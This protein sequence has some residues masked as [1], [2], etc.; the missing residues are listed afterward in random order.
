MYELKSVGRPVIRRQAAGRLLVR[1][2]SRRYSSA[3]LAALVLVALCGPGA[4]AA[5][6][7]DLDP[8]FGSGGKITTGLGPSASVGATEVVIQ[9]D[10]KIVAAGGS[11]GFTLARYNADGNLDAS[12]G[13]SGRVSAGFGSCWPFGCGLA[14]QADGKIVVAGQSNGD[15][16]LARFNPNGSFDTTFDGDGK[17]TTDFGSYDDKAA[18]VAVQPDGKIVA[19]GV[20]NNG[21][22]YGAGHRAEFALARYNPNGSLDASFDGDGKVTTHFDPTY[23]ADAAYD[24]AVRADGT[25][26]VAGVAE[27]GLVRNNQVTGPDFAVAAYTPDGELD[28][29]FGAVDPNNPA[30]R[31]GVTRVDIAARSADYAFSLGLDSHGNIVVGG[32]FYRRSTYG[33]IYQVPDIH[34]VALTRFTPDGLLDPTFGVGGRVFSEFQGYGSPYLPSFDL[35]VQP[36]DKIVIAG[37]SYEFG[38]PGDDFAVARYTPL[39]LLDGAF[40]ANG[41]V[42]T[43]FGSDYEEPYGV[44]VQSD[45]KIV[46]AGGA[47]YYNGS[48]RFD[49][50]LARYLG[51]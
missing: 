9:S 3:L 37:R 43:D 40:G 36:D 47:G 6:P 17:L 19:V 41:I 30:A 22:A 12:F 49:F 39:G 28:T 35:A 34:G 50:A 51:D 42:T 29:S 16:A 25:I 24:V 44:A 7:G 2:R 46:A 48:F 1:G 20:F 15:F 32:Y 18:G 45:G 38:L 10:G 31:A 13:T 27:G 11:N 14:L 5:A 33:L 8:T 26:L 21:S 23:W 4:R